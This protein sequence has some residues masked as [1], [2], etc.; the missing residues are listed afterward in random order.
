[1]TAVHHIELNSH[2][3]ITKN[4]N[5]KADQKIITQ[6]EMVT[7]DFSSETTVQK[8]SNGFHM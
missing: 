1:M 3:Q 7:I 2:R 6:R 5:L 8:K 4:K